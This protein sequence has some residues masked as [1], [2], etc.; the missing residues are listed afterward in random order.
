MALRER[1]RNG[2]GQLPI[3]EPLAVKNG[4][5]SEDAVGRLASYL[6][7]LA[8]KVNGFLSF[9]D[10]SSASWAGNLDGQHV[11][12]AFGV[13]DT[14]VEIPHG[15]GRPVQGY[16]VVRRDR[17]CSVYDSNGG[18]WTD[19]LVLLKCSAANASVRLLVW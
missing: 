4:K 11:T 8:R 5:L 7:T 12:V 17:A 16:F 2:V 18:S 3:P 13:A 6:Q 1:I 10:G 14:E 15:L 9:G 19:S